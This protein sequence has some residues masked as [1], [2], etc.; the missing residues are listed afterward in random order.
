V[1]ESWEVVKTENLYFIDHPQDVLPGSEF[2]VQPYFY[3]KFKKPKNFFLKK[4]KF[5][6]SPE[7][8]TL[9]I[10][11]TVYKAQFLTSCDIH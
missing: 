8:D 9:A 10:S 11:K 3:T 7:S 1:T 6:S 2:R 5:F 4:L